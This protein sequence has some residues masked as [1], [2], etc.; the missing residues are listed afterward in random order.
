MRKL[1]IDEN[2]CVSCG[3]CL[4]YGDYFYEDKSGKAKVYECAFILDKDLLALSDLISLCPTNAINLKD[5]KID[6]NIDMILG[7]LK[8]ELLSSFMIYQPCNM[9][10]YDKDKYQLSYPD[11]PNFWGSDYKYSSESQ[12]LNSGLDE[13]DRYTYSKYR[14]IMV[15]LFVQYKMDKIFPFY[16]LSESGHIAH[17]LQN[18]RMILWNYAGQIN[19]YYN[20]QIL[21][22]DFGEIIIDFN[23]ELIK[24]HYIDVS[25]FERFSTTSGVWADF[26]SE[27]YSSL[28]SY[29][30]YIDTDEME[31][32]VGRGL[33]GDKFKTRYSHRGLMEVTDEFY[34]D[35]Q[36]S[37][38]AV[39]LDEKAAMYVNLFIRAFNY[40]LIKAFADKFKQIKQLTNY[41]FIGA[42]ELIEKTNN[43]S[44][45]DRIL[46]N[47]IGKIDKY[48]Y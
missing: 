26:K 30:S 39:D 20:E 29:K 35:L 14:K 40:L 25:E 7:N 28:S 23:D 36:R 48:L 38:S 18:I 1:F 46:E 13:F 37:M 22:N 47:S 16:D 31:M 17:V 43:Y 21:H 41:E 8:N 5:V 2:T 42:K 4:N 12:A 27:S 9:F 11:S 45:L 33:F 10:T 44:G 19:A 6:D 15:E 24:R 32:Y 3:A 34:S